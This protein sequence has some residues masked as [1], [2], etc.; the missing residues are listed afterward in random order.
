MVS[1]HTPNCIAKS[2]KCSCVNSSLTRSL[3]GVINRLTA[4]P[5]LHSLLCHWWVS[6]YN[7]VVVFHFRATWP[8][9]NVLSSSSLGY[10]LVNCL[11]WLAARGSLV[12]TF[13]HF[14]TLHFAKG[15]LQKATGNEGC[16]MGTAVTDT[17]LLQQLSSVT[18]WLDGYTTLKLGHI[19]QVEHQFFHTYFFWLYTFAMIIIG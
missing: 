9:G 13:S 1:H 4:R 19:T 8:A 5:S 3:G 7:K 15:H 17:L 10:S 12:I 16:R 6:C 11:F 18:I 14:L 2:T